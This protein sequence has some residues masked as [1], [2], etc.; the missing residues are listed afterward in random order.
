[1]STEKSKPESTQPLGRS[2]TIKQSPPG[3]AQSSTQQRPA[4][5]PAILDPNQADAQPDASTKESPEAKEGKESRV[6][7]GSDA[8]KALAPPPRPGQGQQN[9]T[10]DGDYFSGAHNN[11]SHFNLEPNP[12]EQSFGQPS[13]ETP[14]KGLLPPVASI[15]SPAPLTG[16]AQAGSGFN[17]PSSLRSGPLSPAML[18]GPVGSGTDYF[19]EGFKGGFPTPNE[20]S[21]RTG[22]TPGGTGSMFPAPS[23]NSQALYNSLTGGGAT[24]S[25]LDFQKTAMNAAAAKKLE[26]S[27][28]GVTTAKEARAP[29]APMSQ[30][31][32]ANGP[33]S[34]DQQDAANGLFM[35][36][37]ATQGVQNNQFAVPQQ[38]AAVNTSQPQSQETSPTVGRR[39]GRIQNG[40]IGSSGHGFSGLSGE[41]EEEDSKPATRNR[42]KRTNTGRSTGT[43]NGRRKTEETPP[44]QPANK[45]AR[46]QAQSLSG[47]DSDEEMDIKEEQYHAD[48][49]KMTDEDKR[50]NFL[51][52]NR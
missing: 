39:G 30:S 25:T 17:W 7:T 45:K 13:G 21:L 29:V 22:L 9:Q 47:G 8:A 36:A 48:G 42:G 44:K 41:S 16:G 6:A 4:I 35:L 10:S 23:P 28:A 37:N 31:T 19:G 11:N 52:R 27:G 33:N 12:F 1:M 51:E 2:I 26:T 32:T 49:K 40:S 18:G 20:S 38:P 3:T 14:G 43:A 46:T 15:T 5:D 34:L 24:P 50:K